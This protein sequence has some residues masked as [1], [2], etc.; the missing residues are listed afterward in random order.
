[1]SS[2]RLWCVVLCCAVWCNATAIQS[3]C[4]HGLDFRLLCF[5]ICTMV[6]MLCSHT[7]RMYCVVPCSGVCRTLV[8]RSRFSHYWH[9]ALASNRLLTFHLCHLCPINTEAHIHTSVHCDCHSSMWVYIYHHT[10]AAGASFLAS[11]LLL[12]AGAASL[13]LPLALASALSPL[14]PPFDMLEYCCLNLLNN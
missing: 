4:L 10:L 11:A 13:P 6:L 5:Q 12:T 9:H 7:I 3:T 14:L 8:V 2:C 1:M